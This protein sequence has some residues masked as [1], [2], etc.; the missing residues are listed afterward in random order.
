MKLPQ[1]L[2]DEIISY[3]PGYG[4]G[5]LGDYSLVA[6][7]WVRPTQKRIFECVLIHRD[8]LLKSWLKNISPTNAELLGHVRSLLYEP[9]STTE[10]PHH[11][12]RDYLPLLHQ[13]RRLKLQAPVPLLPQQIETFSAFQHTL[14]HINLSMGSVTIRG[15]ITLINYFP[16]L[17]SFSLNG[18]SCDKEYG[19]LP[20]LSR[21]LL[22]KLFITECF[23]HAPEII[24]ELSELG[25]QFDKVDIWQMA[26]SCT[27]PEFTKRVV[28]AFG[29]SVKC[30][31]LWPSQAVCMYNPCYMDPSMSYPQSLRSF[32]ELF[33]TLTLSTTPRIQDLYLLSCGGAEPHFIHHLH[34]HPK[35]NTYPTACEWGAPSEPYLLETTRRGAVQ[36]G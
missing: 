2:V 16:N 18:L 24:D 20:P 25:L 21:P 3:L 12:L 32:R 8:P 34:E 6:K 31:G 11:T 35:D 4:G 29:A 26:L 27:W 22:E 13:L 10:P 5:F 7:Q 30:L 1:E 17:V 28:D 14:S 33:H 19:P 9:P 15:L 36:V 23:T